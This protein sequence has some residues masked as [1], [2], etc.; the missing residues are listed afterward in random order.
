MKTYAIVL[1]SGKG[2]R[3]ESDLPKQFLDICGKPVLAH[4][5][6]AFERNKNVDE[7]I[8]VSHTGY[9]DLADEIVAKYNYKKVK[10]V[11]AGGKT[12]KDSAYNG[13]L[14]VDA[15]T[16]S[17]EEANIAPRNDL[18]LLTSDGSTA[19]QLRK[20]KFSKVVQRSSDEAKVL[21]HDAVRPF[22]TDRIIDDCV[23]EL[24]RCG[25][26]CV[27]IP[28]T[29]TILEVNNENIIE[30]IPERKFLMQ[31]QTPQAFHLSIIKKAHE[32][33]KNESNLNVTD[34]C[35]LV[36]YFQLAPIKIVAGDYTNTKITY[37]IDLVSGEL[38]VESGKLFF[39]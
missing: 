39:S 11:I 2:E 33:A 27:A 29:D 23:R 37:P 7:I 3:F 6:D 8:V 17:V 12:R 9:W 16:S 15:G 36:Q 24:D 20:N 31:S 25:A 14:A 10:K 30:N 32:L 13:I 4:S 38:R 26:V 22:V 34:D 21:I 35:G 18:P 28:A 19:A 1:A 5:L